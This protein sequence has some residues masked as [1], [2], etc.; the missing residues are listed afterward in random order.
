MYS[1]AH[2]LFLYPLPSSSP[3]PSKKAGLPFEHFCSQYEEFLSRGVHVFAPHCLSAPDAAQFLCPHFF[4][5][6]FWVGAGGDLVMPEASPAPSVFWWKESWTKHNPLPL[7]MP[8]HM[9]PLIC[10]SHGVQ[11]WT[12]LHPSFCSQDVTSLK[13]PSFTRPPFCRC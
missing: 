1:H 4:A 2:F 6:D 9:P 11:G 10:I 5:L 7:A 3:S 13:W 8:M 12:K